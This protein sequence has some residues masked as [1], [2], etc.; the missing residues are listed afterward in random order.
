M[1]LRKGKALKWILGAGFLLYLGFLP[2]YY[3]GYFND[4]AIYILTA[5]SLLHGHFSTL[6]LPSEPP[7]IHY[8]PG[9]SLLLAPF[10]AVLGPHW[11]WLKGVPV[12]M[13][14]GSGFFLWCLLG[15]P[16]AARTRALLVTLFLFHPLA[17]SYSGAVMSDSCFLFFV[18][19]ALVRLKQTL[20][21]TSDHADWGLSLLCA[22]TALIRPDGCVLLISMVVA[23]AYAKRWKTLLSVSLLGVLAWGGL[24]LRNYCLAHTG[25][26]Y[27]SAWSQLLPYVMQPGQLW[28]NFC[29]LLRSLSRMVVGF[30]W[31]DLGILLAG[32]GAWRVWNT[33]A[34]DRHVFAAI[35]TLCALFVVLHT[36]WA[37]EDRHFLMVL[38]FCLWFTLEGL[39]AFWP[40]RLYPE[41]VFWALGLL[42][43]LRTDAR[44]LRDTWSPSRPIETLLPGETYTWIGNHT[45]REAVFVGKAAT[46]ALYTG[47]HGLQ[48][49]NN[50]A[51]QEEFRHRLLKNRIGFIC[52]QPRRIAALQ[53]PTLNQTIG[54]EEMRR[55]PRKWPEAFRPIYEN[56]GEQTVVYEVLPNPPY[57]QAYDAYLSARKDLAAGDYAAAFPKLDQA[58]H[59]YPRIADVYCARGTGFLLQGNH[60]GEAE[61][62]FRQALAMRPAYPPALLNLARI[63]EE[64]KE[65]P[66][67][68]ET[69]L[70][71]G[72]SISSYSEFENLLPTITAEISSL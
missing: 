39:L 46:I 40:T 15:A 6:H 5:K 22:W 69:L 23:L 61:A 60:L 72:R 36:L 29:S 33:Q 34:I 59:L 17:A 70:Q 3:V 13:T 14:L 31:G 2:R 50:F 1:E 27:L 4:D 35:A 26:D 66:R 64:R 38:P 19:A 51:D 11:S 62:Q 20:H 9:F 24:F 41:P 57:V 56:P 58:A 54:W 18:L 47:R 45:P 7:M 42:M 63:Y 43:C 48:P 71:A 32:L 8:P 12:L 49:A 25:I 68:K 67:A 52:D 37:P 65:R 21:G 16:P 10:V 44:L 28:Q 55:W 53:G 30:G